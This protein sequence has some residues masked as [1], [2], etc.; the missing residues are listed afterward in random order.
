MLAA[1]LRG[2]APDAALVGDPQVA[3]DRAAED[4][5]KDEEAEE[6][7]FYIPNQA[8]AHFAGNV[9][10]LAVGGGW[11]WMEHAFDLDLLFGWVPPLD[12]SD[13]LYIG[14]LKITA[15]PLDLDLGRSWH[16]RP[17]SAGGFASL[18]F[19]DEYFLFLPD[20]YPDGYYTFSTALRFGAFLGGSIGHRFGHG[21]LKRANL[22]WELGITDLELWLYLQNPR[23]LRIVDVLHVAIGVSTS[24]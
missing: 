16:L 13:A 23:A 22:Y 8:K 11:S 24:F 14:T 9:G 20:R 21:F 4:A 17:I 2:L 15:W 5:S 18:T 1:A 19:G 3:G 6:R 10:L 12:G 7:P